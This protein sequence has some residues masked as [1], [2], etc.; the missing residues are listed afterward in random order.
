MG[1]LLYNAKTTGPVT[2][3]ALRFDAHADWLQLGTVPADKNNF[4]VCCWVKIVVDRDSYS[5]AWAFEDTGGGNYIELVT[6][7]DGTSMAVFDNGGAD[8]VKSMTTGVWYFVGVKVGA[9]GALTTYWGEEGAGS[10]TKQTGTVVSAGSFNLFW[11]GSTYYSEFFSGDLAQFR[12]WDAQLSDAEFNDEFKSSLLVRTS[13]VVGWWKLDS[14]STRTTD[15]SGNGNTLTESGS[16]AW[17]EVTGP[18]IGNP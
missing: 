13:D 6:D 18:T 16:G 5:C 1:L 15:A 3:G 17:T 11:I 8:L 7:F 4:S 9:S 12:V 14:N 2:V 10:L